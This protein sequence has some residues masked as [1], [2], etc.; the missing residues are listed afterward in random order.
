[1]K[2]LPILF[3]G[4]MVRAI[5]AGRK[6]QTRR[7]IKPQPQ[8][9]GKRLER[10]VS[11][12]VCGDHLWVRETFSIPFKGALQWVYR[13]DGAAPFGKWKPSIFMPRAFS[14][15][16]LEIISVRVER[17][18]QISGAD[19]VAEGINCEEPFKVPYCGEYVATAKLRYRHLWESINGAGSWAENPWVWVIGFKKLLAS[20]GGCGSV[21]A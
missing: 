4:P 14:R 17:L 21:E 11:P 3:S 2:E 8:P 7:I 19:A 13:A 10:G 1:M 6:T 9:N 18:Q 5:I 16:T 12:W 15:L 20:G